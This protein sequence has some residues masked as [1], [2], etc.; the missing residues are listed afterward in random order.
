MQIVEIMGLQM[1]EERDRDG[2]ELD[3]VA[4]TETQ[5]AALRGRKGRGFRVL[6]IV[7]G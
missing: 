6:R 1:Y 5:G 4:K 3:M 7:R 2:M